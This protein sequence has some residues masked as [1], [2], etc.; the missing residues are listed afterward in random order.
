MWIMCG[1]APDAF[2]STIDPQGRQ[3]KT[4]GNMCACASCK[5]LR[6]VDFQVFS[7]ENALLYYYYSHKNH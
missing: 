2:C 7:T 4:A 3:R 1:V 5:P 6:Y